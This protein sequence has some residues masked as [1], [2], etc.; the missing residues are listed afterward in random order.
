MSEIDQSSFEA[1][2]EN[3]FS[4]KGKTFLELNKDKKNILLIGP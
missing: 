1:I 4:R 3:K 2:H